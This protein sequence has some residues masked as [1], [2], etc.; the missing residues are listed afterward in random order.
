M[1]PVSDRDPTHPTRTTENTTPTDSLNII[2]GIR[3]HVQN[4]QCC[5]T[6]LRDTFFAQNN[7]AVSTGPETSEPA[8]PQIRPSV[9]YLHDTDADIYKYNND[10]FQNPHELLD[11]VEC[12]ERDKAHIQ[13]ISELKR[14]RRGM[15]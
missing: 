8:D 14:K 6:A 11:K 5:K 13:N 1:S 15:R 4:C 10:D 3:V 7:V 12:V 2:R 9:K